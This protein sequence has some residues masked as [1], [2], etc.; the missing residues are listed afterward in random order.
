MNTIYD[1]S[2]SFSNM[3]HCSAHFKGRSITDGLFTLL[4]GGDGKTSKMGEEVSCGKFF[5]ISQTFFFFK[6]F[7]TP[8]KIHPPPVGHHL[9]AF[10]GVFP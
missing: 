8:S 7:E 3:I 6:S 5:V 9:W 10:R 1:I 4:K 2:N